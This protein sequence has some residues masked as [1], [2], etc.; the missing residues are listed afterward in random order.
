[1]I[2]ALFINDDSQHL[3][4]YV[5]LTASLI[6]FHYVLTS[7]ISAGKTRGRTFTPEFMEQNFK[8]LHERH[9]TEEGKQKVVPKGGYPDMGSGRF[10]EKLSYKQWYEFNV[11]QRI[12]Y[13]YL[14]SIT[15]VICW[16]L[17]A[18]L[19]YPE[20]SIA[21]GGGYF[22]GRV[23]FHMGYAMKGPQGRGIGFAL[24]FLCSLGLMIVAFIS[25][26][27]LGVRA[28]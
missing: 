13:H 25:S 26:I 10:S 3:Y 27:T 9:F 24:Q 14:E 11:A 21:F 28:V 17:I 7:F 6:L 15:S 2:K 18:G 23:L 4:R 20:V 19:V 1:M 22:L 5:A 12:H 8:T 16:L